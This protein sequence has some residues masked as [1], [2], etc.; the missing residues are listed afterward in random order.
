MKVAVPLIQGTVD[1]PYGHSL[2]NDI[3][4]VWV[5]CTRD[6]IHGLLLRVGIEI[7]D[8]PLA[9]VLNLVKFSVLQISM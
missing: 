8:G 5:I 3:R 4:N 9:N 6:A 7:S 2:T 1:Y